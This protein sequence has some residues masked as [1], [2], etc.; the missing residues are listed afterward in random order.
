LTFSCYTDRSQLSPQTPLAKT[1]HETTSLVGRDYL[2]TLSLTKRDGVSYRNYSTK[3]TDPPEIHTNPSTTAT[4]SNS[5]LSHVDAQGKLQMVDVSYKNVTIREAIAQAVV[6]LSPEA[7]HAVLKNQLK[8]GDVTTVA[9]IAG[10]LGAKQTSS[11]IPL[12]HPLPLSKV[13]VKLVLEHEFRRIRITTMAKTASTTGVEM[14]ALTAASI[15][16]LTIYDMCKSIDHHIVITDIRLLK[17]TGGKSDFAE[18]SNLINI[19]D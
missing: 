5:D 4:A 3:T 7:F 10:I 12:C 9:Q 2:N 6:T 8:K 17:K 18:S 11:L 14:E 19:K 1:S 13:D 16:A 15:A